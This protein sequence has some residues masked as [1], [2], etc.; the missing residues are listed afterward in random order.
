MITNKWGVT[1][2]TFIT[3]RSRAKI[4][5]S[6]VGGIPETQR[7]I[8][9]WAENKIYPEIEVISADGINEAWEKVVNKEACYRYVIDS[10]TI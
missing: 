2:N 3:H 10:A 6:L 1:M 9:Y 8:K 5:T 7:L 4:S